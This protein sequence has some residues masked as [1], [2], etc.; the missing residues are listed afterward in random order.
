MKG[1]HTIKTKSQVPLNN[2]EAVFSEVISHISTLYYSKKSKKFLPKSANLEVMLIFREKDHKFAGTVTFDLASFPN[3][4]VK[5]LFFFEFCLKFDKS[6][7]RKPAGR[8]S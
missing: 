1:E 8:Q 6:S 7:F 4:G 2:K 3:S 5:S